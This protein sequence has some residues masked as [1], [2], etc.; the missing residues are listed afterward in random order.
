MVIA[1]VK[2]VAVQRVDC[3]HG[4]T[5]GTDTLTLALSIGGLVVAILSVGLATYAAI[6]S[7]RSANAA[8]ESLMMAREEH[9]EFM[10]D[11]R[12]HAEFELSVSLD[13]GRDGVIETDQ[14][15]TA[16]YW[17][18]GFNNTKGEKPAA[19]AG[20]NFLVP[21]DLYNLSWRSQETGRVWGA[22]HAMTAPELLPA[23]DGTSYPTRY[24]EDRVAPV[25]RTTH[26]VSFAQ[27]EVEVPRAP[28]DERIVPVKFKVWSD[29][30]EPNENGERSRWVRHETIIRRTKPVAHPA[31]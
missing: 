10:R 21:Q 15:R 20:I 22:E 14:D 26:Y 31:R 11:L 7:R 19:A 16:L 28:G 18:A 13:N 12:A 3:V 2:H 5:N 8:A 27:A 6:Q 9:A 1:A 24:L 23:A 4:C 17:T 29:D 25:D 30:L